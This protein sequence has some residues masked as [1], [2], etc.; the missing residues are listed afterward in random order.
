MDAKKCDRCGY[1]YVISEE[2]DLQ[3]AFTRLGETMSRVLGGVQPSLS[4]RIE[5]HVDLCDECKKDL[6][7]WC[8]GGVDL[9][10]SKKLW[11][12]IKRDRRN[13]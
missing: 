6:V 3:S 12:W 7:V 9:S 11:G 13:S 8:E 2:S 1:F 10:H 4:E 5:L